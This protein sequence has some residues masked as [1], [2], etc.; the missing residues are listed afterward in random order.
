MNA[1]DKIYIDDL[2]VVNDCVTKISLKRLPNFSEYIRKDAL[3]EAK[4]Y[5]KIDR[6]VL[7][8]I[9][10]AILEHD[11]Y[12]DHNDCPENNSECFHGDWDMK[13]R[14]KVENIRNNS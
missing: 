10:D 2:A 3:L 7:F 11:G 6:K 9:C 8:E 14:K 5:V 12:S 1:P 4:H 13:F